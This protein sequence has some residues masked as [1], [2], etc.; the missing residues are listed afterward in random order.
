[1]A[2]RGCSRADAVAWL[3]ERVE[4]NSRVDVDFDALLG[5]APSIQ[6]E[7][8][9]PPNEEDKPRGG[10]NFEQV[11]PWWGGRCLSYKNSNTPQPWIV[12]RTVPLAGVG[13]MSGQT[14]AAKSWLSVHL[15][16]CAR[17]PFLLCERASAPYSCASG[18]TS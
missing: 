7:Q 11:P 6:P 9:P 3:Q 14:G 8:Q 1:M 13:L 12:Q 18:R 2:A 10:D 16:A 5:D 15:S 4:P 17:L